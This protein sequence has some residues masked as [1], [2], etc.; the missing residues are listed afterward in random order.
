[1][2]GLAG[3]GAVHVLFGTPAGLDA[4]RD[5]VLHQDTTGVADAAERDDSFGGPPESGF[6]RL[7]LP[8]PPA[9]FRRTR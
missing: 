7:G 6:E 2:G 9:V 5:Q 1:M 4:A 3:A 8:T